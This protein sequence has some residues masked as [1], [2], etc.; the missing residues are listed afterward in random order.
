[1]KNFRLRFK[2]SLSFDRLS[3]LQM[4][5]SFWGL[6]V[7]MFL[8]I[9]SGTNAW[10]QDPGGQDTVYVY[11]SYAAIDESQ[12][13]KV[14]IEI[15]IKTDNTGFNNDI[16]GMTVP[17]IITNS[18][19]AANPV[20]D[21]TVEAT[22]GFSAVQLFNEIQHNVSG[23]P[24]SF[25]VQTTLGAFTQQ[26]GL[27]A[28]DYRFATLVIHL[29]DTTTLCIDTIT[30]GPAY[31]NLTLG[32]SAD[33]IPAFQSLCQPVSTYPAGM[34][35]S[36][37]DADSPVDLIVIDPNNDSIGVS[38]NTIDSAFYDVINDSISI[39][40]TYAGEYR[41]KVVLDTLDQSGES[42][43]SIS[44]RID[45]TAD[46]V[47]AN[48]LPVPDTGEVH[49]IEIQNVPD[50][51]SI[52]CFSMPGDA[53]ADDVIT[54]S[55]PIATVN[56]I[57]NKAGCDPLPICWLKGLLCRGDWNGSD[58]VTL[59]DVIRAVNYVFNKPGGPWNAV[60]IG[61]CCL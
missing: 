19:P 61:P 2:N 55:D 3:P 39:Y 1:M 7:L 53:N 16:A 13:G 12:G 42:T 50:S 28:G 22:F 37:F 45:G 6:A 54:L 32:S 41:I 31:L 57:F 58:T 5:S 43:Y 17:L 4:K 33:Y 36:Y 29:D 18:N 35:P 40:S 21:T 23:D 27:T 46:V 52:G 60:Q 49:Q 8:I 44:A 51:N 47:V 10:A 56:Y 26:T 14:R 30:I 48:N 20:L 9:A 11:N 59:A 15:W 34:P 38:F 24:S 25:P